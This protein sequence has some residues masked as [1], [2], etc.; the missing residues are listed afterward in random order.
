MKSLSTK[1]LLLIIFVVAVMV[2]LAY[3]AVIFKSSERELTESN[4]ETVTLKLMLYLDKLEDNTFKIQLNSTKYLAEKNPENLSQCNDAR[5]HI[6]T[7][8]TVLDSVKRY[9]VY[10]NKEL[11][12]LD[13]LERVNLTICGKMTEAM[14][15]NQL[16]IY[17]PLSD[18]ILKAFK[19]QIDKVSDYGRVILHE[20]K[21][22]S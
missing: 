11:G 13:S 19:L 10:L 9:N 1:R 17:Y 21:K 14:T 15:G 8:L 22:Q 2:F 3:C 4:K 6:L 12:I 20:Y 7:C 18:K 5:E 16:N